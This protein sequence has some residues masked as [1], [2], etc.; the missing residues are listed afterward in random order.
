MMKR[1]T[2]EVRPSPSE[3]NRQTH[4]TSAKPDQNKQN[5]KLTDGAYFLLDGYGRGHN[6]NGHACIFSRMCGAW[7]HPLPDRHRADNGYGSPPERQMS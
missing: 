2:T 6:T 5:S 1:N 7:T 3:R 4:A